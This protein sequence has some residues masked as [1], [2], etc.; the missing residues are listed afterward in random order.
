MMDNQQ[1]LEKLIEVPYNHLEEKERL[2]NVLSDIKELNQLQDDLSNIIC[3]QGENINKIEEVSEKTV[4]TATYANKELEA[5]SGRKFKMLP[6]FLGT[7]VGVA[8]TLPITIGF[9]L[10]SAAI[11]GIVAGGSVIGGV[12]G[13]NLSK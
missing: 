1:I 3:L 4:E 5:A 13:K 2:C 12:L 7:G 10:S 8:V 6:I 11:G 9:G